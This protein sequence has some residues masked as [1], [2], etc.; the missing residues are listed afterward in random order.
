MARSLLQHLLKFR[1][2]S[3][4]ETPRRSLHSRWHAYL[5]KLE[6]LEE[7]QTPT[8][9]FATQVTFAS[10]FP[11]GSAMGLAQADINGD[12]KPDLIA[13]GDN[14]SVSVLLNTTAAGSTTPTYAA[15]QT[16]SVGTPST[17][18][19]AYAVAVGDFNGDGKPDLVV[20]NLQDATVSVLVNTTATNSS[21]VTFQPPKTFAVQSGPTA[22]AVAD[23]NGDGK[24]DIVVTDNLTF[25]VSVLINT[26]VAGNLSFAAQQTFNVGGTPLGVAV[27]DFN[28]DGKPDIAVSNSSSNSVSVL[29]NTTATGA[30]TPS[31][32]AQRTFA[33][34][35]QPLSVT[36]V[37]ING[38]GKLDL[39]VPNGQDNTVS[40]LLNATP[41]RASAPTFLAQQTFAVGTSPSFVVAG[42]FDQNGR[43]DLAVANNG[44]NAMGVLINTTPVA[45]TTV[46]FAAQQTFAVGA[47][48]TA[49]VV[50]DINGDGLTDL[51]VANVN[52][53]T[54]S[55]LINTTAPTADP[56]TLTTGQGQPLN[57]TLTAATTTPAFADS[58]TSGASP[59]WGDEVGNWTA[60]GGVYFAQSPSNNPA[61]YSSL[62][63]TVAD[64]SFDV[65]VNNLQDGGVWLRSSLQNGLLNGVLLVTGGNSGTGT[66]LYWNI[67]TNNS[68]TGN[69]NPVNG[70]FTPGVSNAHLHI[71]VAGNTYSV[72][73][74]GSTT[75]ATTL[76]TNSFASGKVA[77]YDFSPQTFDNVSLT[78]HAAYNSTL[79]FAITANPSHG[80]LSNFNA[81]TGAVTYTPNANY[82]GPDTFQFT[83]ADAKTGF[84]SAAATVSLT[85]LPQPASFANQ[86]LFATGLP[87]ASTA[88]TF[89]D[90]NGDNKPDLIVVGGSTLAVLLNTTPTGTPNPSFGAAQTFAVGNGADAVAAM[91][92]DGDN[93]PDLV[94]A[95]ATDNTVSLLLNT[96][97]AG[98]STV[99]FAAAQ[100]FA[101]GKAP[102]ALAVSD[103]D[104]DNKPDIIVTNATDNTLSVLVNTT[105]TPGTPTFAAQ[106]T[107]AVGTSPQGV[108][109]ADIN[110]DTKP[111]LV[112][113]NGGPVGNAT[114]S[115]LL[116]TTTG[117]TLSLAAQQTFAAGP[118][119][120]AVAVADVNGDNKPD[121]LVGQSAGNAVSLLL[122]TTTTNST[123]ASFAPL[124][125]FTAG[126]SPVAVVGGDFNGDGRPDLAA[127]NSGGSTVSVLASTTPANATTAS[128][129]AAQAFNV[130]SSPTAE[131][132][133]DF[134][135]NGL[136]DLAVLNS[137]SG[138]VSI[139]MNTT[140]PIAV[141]QTIITG[142]G[143]AV[144]VTLAG[145]APNNDAFTFAIS[146]NP[147][148]GQLSALN[149]NHQVKY[150]PNAGYNGPDSFTFTVTDTK[151]GYTATATITITVLPPPTAN[152]QSIVMGENLAKTITLTGFAPNGDKFTFQIATNPAH[153]TLSNFNAN[154]GFVT[155]TPAANYV[156]NDSFTFTVTDK[157][158]NL[159]S[160]PAT[161]SIVVL[162]PPTATSETVTVAQGRQT[163]VTLFYSGPGNDP[164][165]YSLKAAPAHGTLSDLN[166]SNQ[167][168]FTANASYVGPDSF[169]F[170]ITDTATT[171][172][173]TAT[174]SIT[175]AVPPTANAQSVSAG[176]ATIVTLTGGAPNNDPISFAVTN[177]PTHGTLSG[178][179]AS[180][181][182]VTYTPNSSYSGPDNFTF[183][184]TDTSTGL[185]TSAVVSVTVPVG[186]V[187]Q[188]GNQGVWQFSRSLN[189]WVQLTP[190][191][192]SVV[193]EDALGDVVA[194]FPNSGVWRLTPAAGWSQIS[195]ANASI[196]VS[197]AQGNVTAEF[198]NSGVWQYRPD[199]FH[200]FG[201]W[202][203]L[204]TVDASLLAAGAGGV[205]VGNFKGAGLWEFLP[206]SGWTQINT[207]DATALAMD[208]PGDVV[209]TYHGY[210]V[211]ELQ[212]GSGWVQLTNSE[213]SVLAI[214][215]QRNVVAEFPNSGVW[216]HLASGWR[217]LT[218]ANASILV[219]NA[220][221]NIFAEFIGAGVWK[222]DPLRGWIQMSASDASSL[223]VN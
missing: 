218:P 160:T 152:A 172:S 19:D 95:N 35:N 101:V 2:S 192:A 49:A 82:S 180:T 133:M 87:S 39:V 30:T 190:A 191:N 81:N 64:F 174:V 132:V 116:N 33:T 124:Q 25:H 36:A 196:L 1:T 69:L 169:Q 130:G 40:V 108:V 61:T 146:S 188:F 210:G 131:I 15:A 84:A 107:F 111:D 138:T 184:V 119:P 52:A 117:G 59:L 150:T 216:Q 72:Y 89:A 221:G 63:Y 141:P 45:T 157:F 88:M 5:P 62:P 4:K 185:V 186:P 115:V 126:S 28:A 106:Q 204:T 51:A 73:V 9:S 112:V 43:P 144:T 3:G 129:V 29:L 198:P 80:T 153:G 217:Q 212:S 183:T 7:R 148:H 205:A 223:G 213:A 145:S 202:T 91:D 16:F 21:T 77:L 222:F 209:A 96:T 97:A 17:A 71:V 219:T 170:T 176:Q 122:N 22:V 125:T 100:T 181:G 31:F 56:Q 10:G 139:L 20:T 32:S 199:Q 14:N 136:P 58:F 195:L 57:I 161:V 6:A 206:T 147:A 44:D 85:V 99:T 47:A 37:D 118:N 86:L 215:A 65:D 187:G 207:V 23:F 220:S 123:T 93:K 78:L 98:S 162:G 104:G 67:V 128:F 151:T 166:S 55:A 165:A 74:N 79:V 105:T 38:D 208:A 143:Q 163:I 66:G 103:L 92:V 134:D 168:V 194:E 137:G 142:Q 109:V 135:K 156:G 197:D 158:D 76:T 94:V 50:S 11:A 83:A 193:V 24:P 102:S 179:S 154:T 68:N 53:S 27:G 155:Y 70:L 189:N 26:T 173:S 200:P 121:L 167:V 60:S 201:T 54:V 164:L 46:T 75:P 182:Q 34:G 114:V 18:N 12:G 13:V 48:P 177:Q 171:L 211:A 42:D 214:D 178:F 113:S 90:V 120:H 203:Q 159:V 175:V 41:N 110:G 149:A 127:A 8:V 140:P